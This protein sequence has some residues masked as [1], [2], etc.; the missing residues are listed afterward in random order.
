MK[1]DDRR[2]TVASRMQL[3]G[4]RFESLRGVAIGYDE[5]GEPVEAVD[6]L[7]LSADQREHL[8]QRLQMVLLRLERG[9]ATRL[10]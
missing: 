2:I 9:G 3:G 7:G 1:Q 4:V 8:K 5:C 10:H 6:F